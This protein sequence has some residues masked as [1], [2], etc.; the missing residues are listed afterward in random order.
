MARRQSGRIP[1]SEWTDG[2]KRYGAN[3][4]ERNKRMHTKVCWRVFCLLAL[5]RLVK[6]TEVICLLVRKSFV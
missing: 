1:S 2:R 4:R 3:E 5:C 6:R